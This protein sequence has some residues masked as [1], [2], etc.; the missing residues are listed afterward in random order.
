MFKIIDNS[1]DIRANYASVH[2]VKALLL[3]DKEKCG[4]ER[5]MKELALNEASAR[6]MLRNLEKNGLIKSSYR[7]RLLAPRGRKF[8][9]ALNKKVSG[10]AMVMKTGITMSDCN[11]AYLVKNAARKIRKGV[12]QRDQAILMG[13][14]GL[15][16]LLHRKKLFMPGLEKWK[17]PREIS[18]MFELK[19]DDV[20]L[21]GSAK[22][23]VK[24][25]LAALNAAI[26]LL[27]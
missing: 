1:I 10:P 8:I 13:A 17:V 25:D 20:I 9:E 4:R 19:E 24:A 3:I 21:I 14:Q 12:E 18:S 7:G 16:T 15:T 6:T 5:L 11:I 22:N 27:R 26:N 23:A 2:V